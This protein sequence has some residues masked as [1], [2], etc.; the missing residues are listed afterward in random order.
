MARIPPSQK[1]HGYSFVNGKA[2]PE[3]TAWSSMKHRCLNPK[4]KNYGLY[5]GR[6]IAVCERWIDDFAAFLADMGHRPSAGLS[7]DRVDN[8]GDYEPGNCRWA[9]GRQQSN[10][11]RNNHTIVVD[12]QTMTVTQAARAKGL[13]IYLV[14]TRIKRGWSIERALR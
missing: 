3:Y 9:D 7:L 8:D 4:A 13:N 5:G 6:G 2:S 12:G 11:K 1:T 14:R 10:N